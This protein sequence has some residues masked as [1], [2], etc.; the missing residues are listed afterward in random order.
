MARPKTA[1][2]VADFHIG[3]FDT[4]G[5]LGVVLLFASIVVVHALCCIRS[6]VP[7]WRFG[8]V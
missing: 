5:F 2:R 8:G 1:A 4:I 3:V 7:D 6:V